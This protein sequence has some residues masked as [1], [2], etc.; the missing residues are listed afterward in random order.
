MSVDSQIREVL[1]ATQADVRQRW[2]ELSQESR[3]WVTEQVEQLN[4]QAQQL[5]AQSRQ[6]RN[7]LRREARQRRKL[8]MLLRESGTVFGKDLLKRGSELTQNLKD[9]GGKTTSDL[10]ARGGELTQGLTRRSGKITDELARR[11]ERLLEPVQKRDRTFWTVVGFGVGLA[12]AGVV[13][14]QLVRRR[15]AQQVTEQDEHIELPQNDAWNGSVGRPAGEIRHI[16]Q[17]GTSVATLEIV[18]VETV[19]RPSDAAFVG[20]I[21]TKLY[22]PVDTAI[23]PNDLVVYFPTEEEARTEGFTAAM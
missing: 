21:N 5:Q 15:M 17:G 4:E 11:G 1:Q 18:D 19:E 13:T 2:N 23:D 6:L 7:A 12:A 16:D 3:Q 8:L 22:Y 9:F 10:S 20:V 14:Y